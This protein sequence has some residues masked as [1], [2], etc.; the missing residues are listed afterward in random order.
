MELMSRAVI[1]HRT[2]RPLPGEITSAAINN[3]T[4][5]ATAA[6]TISAQGWLLQIVTPSSPVKA[7][8]GPLQINFWYLD[9]GDVQ[10]AN[11]S[12]IGLIG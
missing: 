9:N 7:S 12:V 1:K 11:L 8:R 2:L 4:G 6:N 5:S 10:S 3:A